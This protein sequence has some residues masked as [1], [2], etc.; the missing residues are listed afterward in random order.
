MTATVSTY[1]IKSA[2][3]RARTTGTTVLDWLRG[4]LQ[5]AARQRQ[6]RHCFGRMA[7]RLLEDVGI[8]PADIHGEFWRETE[9]QRRR[10]DRTKLI[11]IPWR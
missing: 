3:R 1:R 7:P 11:L 10:A 5:A 9:R 2:G 4:R 6:L 8:D